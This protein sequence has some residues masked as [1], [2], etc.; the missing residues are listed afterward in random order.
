MFKCKVIKTTLWFGADSNSVICLFW[1]QA[2]AGFESKSVCT[3]SSQN[4]AALAMFCTGGCRWSLLTLFLLR[5]GQPCLGKA[6]ISLRLFV[7]YPVV[8][9]GSSWSS[10]AGGATGRHTR[11]PAPKACS[12]WVRQNRRSGKHQR[13][14]QARGKL[15]CFT[16]GQ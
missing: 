1:W 16:Q 15:W 11:A 8:L 2:K 10:E 4:G 3:I 14:I 7:I 5:G 13:E 9:A 12:P 6:G